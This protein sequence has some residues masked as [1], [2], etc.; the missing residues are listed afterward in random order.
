MGVSL[1]KDRQVIL[2]ITVGKLDIS[3]WMVCSWVVSIEPVM[4]RPDTYVPLIIQNKLYTL[5][6]SVMFVAPLFNLVSFYSA[7]LLRSG[8]GQACFLSGRL[9]LTQLLTLSL[10]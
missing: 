1:A 4:A 6:S 5:T 2:S 3:P 10:L 9:S 8:Y 7:C